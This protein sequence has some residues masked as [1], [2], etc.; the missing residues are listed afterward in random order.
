MGRT[1]GAIASVVFVAS[2]LLLSACASPSYPAALTDS[3][4]ESMVQ[5]TNERMWTSFA[6]QYPGVER[7]AVERIAFVASG[8]WAAAYARCLRFQGVTNAVAKNEVL[9]YGAAP[10][11]E[12]ET[13]LALYVCSAEFPVDPR[14]QGYLS[15]AQI[16]YLADYFENRT[17]PCLRL[18]GYTIPEPSL[19][20]QFAT[21]SLVGALWTP[22]DF[23]GR[24]GGSAPWALIDLRC[25]P[26]PQDV[27][28]SFHP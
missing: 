27:F 17:A 3:E 13:D 16:S 10:G 1:G 28:G 12:L 9:Y 5:A 15:A 22:Y 7:P 8:T 4:V 6:Y 18:L 11:A 21:P 19:R 23:V 20:E 24:V 2:A 26:P 14:T 25:P